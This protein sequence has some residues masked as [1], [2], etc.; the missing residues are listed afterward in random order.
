MKK[1]TKRAKA[2]TPKEPK[3]DPTVILA[4]FAADYERTISK[5]RRS[6]GNFEGIIAE[7]ISEAK[8]VAKIWAKLVG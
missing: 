6:P 5:A 3:P 8:D 7:K 4:I 1:Q 2:A